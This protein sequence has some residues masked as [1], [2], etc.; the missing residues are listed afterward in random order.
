MVTQDIHTTVNLSQ[1]QA[2]VLNESAGKLGIKRSR[3][4]AMLL[5]KILAKWE[6]KQGTFVSV[7]YQKD[8]SGGGWK[9]VHVFFEAVDYEVF[10]DMRNFFKWSVSALLAEA[11]KL[12]LD[13]ILAC[14]KKKFKAYHN[15]YLI[16]SYERDGKLYKNNICWHINWKLGAEFAKEIQK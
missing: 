11:I 8:M 16:H 13:E 4:A 9:R 6:K 1:S 2:M 14:D 3:L 7:R 10:T 5:R 12:Y 15:K